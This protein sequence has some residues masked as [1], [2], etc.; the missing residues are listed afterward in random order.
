MKKLPF[1]TRQAPW[2]RSK[3]AGSAV[4]P[5]KKSLIKYV[6][7]N[8][9]GRCQ[10]GCISCPSLPS[11]TDEKISKTQTDLEKEFKLFQSFFIKL[12][13]FGLE[14]VTLYGREPTLWDQESNPPNK[15]LKELIIWLS[16]ELKVRVCLAT[17]GISLHESVLRVLFNQQGVLFMKNWGAKRSVE[18]LIRHK[19]AYLKIQKSWKLVKSLSTEYKKT[20]VIAEFL[21]TGINRGDLLAFWKNCCLQGFLPFVEV[22]I[23][24]GSCVKNYAQLKIDPQKYIQDIYALSLLNLS[25]RYGLSLAKARQSDIW[26]PPYGSVFPSAC[27]KL[28]LGRGVFLERNGN[29]SVC[30][31]V[32][33]SLGNLQDLKIENKL[34]N[35]P[36]LKRVRRSY[37]YLEGFCKA[38]AYSKKFH[39]C[40]GCRGNGYTY[41][42]QGQGAFAQDPMC[43]GK[44]ALSL[45]AQGKLEKFMSKQHIEKTLL[46]FNH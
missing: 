32:D 35:H 18:Q 30:C 16:Q 13:K 43:F 29:L 21:Y 7:F 10:A 28:T 37:D 42:G 2:G 40:Y 9:T 33:K 14:F 15:F 12:K 25:L 24:K 23:I 22:P 5:N 31:G 34:R 46:Y 1:P 20:T 11:Y 38:C 17:S 4:S 8:L 26:Q 6:E 44:I 19:G 36:L 45:A 41:P 39:L 27:D 3:T